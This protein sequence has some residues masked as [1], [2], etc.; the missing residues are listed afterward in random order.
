MKRIKTLEKNG[1]AKCE[2][3]K[4]RSQATQHLNWCMTVMMGVCSMMA[5][6]MA[7]IDRGRGAPAKSNAGI[8]FDAIGV[9]A[10]ESEVKEDQMQ[11]MGRDLKAAIPVDSHNK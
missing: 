1:M 5:E 10:K 7:L 9:V 6:T 8:Y 3:K 11:A 2:E 4:S